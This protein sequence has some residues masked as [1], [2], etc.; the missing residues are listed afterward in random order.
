MAGVARPPLE[1]DSTV[2][3]PAVDTAW[4]AYTAAMGSFIDTRP[5]GP[6]AE[7]ARQNAMVEYFRD[8]DLNAARALWEQQPEPARDPTEMAMLADI[9][10]NTGFE[11]ALTFIDRLRAYQPG[12][13][14]V[15]LTSL[16]LRQARIGEAVSAVEAAL[17]RFRTDP[18]PMTRYMEHA[19]QLANI[20]ANRDAPTAR[21]IYDALS[22]PFSVLASEE[23]RLT[24]RAEVSKLVDF[25]GLCREAVGALEPSVPWS[26]SFLRL[27]RDCYQVTSSPLLE[28]A[29]RELDEFLANAAQPLLPAP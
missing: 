11:G 4:L 15:M 9:T 3:W 6:P 12:E 23:L 18:W 24:T 29:N 26:E 22:Q 17:T 14:D 21:R 27:R 19:L 7:Q 13:A 16:R 25:P 1:N 2:Q 5:Q 10:A 8:D 28:V 20:L